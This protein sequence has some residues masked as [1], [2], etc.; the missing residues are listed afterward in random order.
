MIVSSSGISYLEIILVV[1]LCVG[2][3]LHECLRYYQA[4]GSRIDVYSLSK[5]KCYCIIIIVIVIIIIYCT[6]Y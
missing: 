3:R 6:K 4:L 2:V 5:Y 1:L